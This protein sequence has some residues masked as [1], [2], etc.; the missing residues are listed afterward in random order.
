MSFVGSV[1]RFFLSDNQEGIEACNEVVALAME[2]MIEWMHGGGQLG[3]F[4]A[5][6]STRKRRYMLMKM[7]E[8]NCKIIFL[9]TI[10]NDQNIIERNVCLKI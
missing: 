10:C 5:T 1:C 7:A 2:D 3:I 6:N 4:D 8:G 9:E